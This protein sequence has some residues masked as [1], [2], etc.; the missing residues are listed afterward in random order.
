MFFVYSTLNSKIPSKYSLKLILSNVITQKY[1]YFDSLLVSIFLRTRR[2]C[3]IK[4]RHAPDS[5]R[6]NADILGTDEDSKFL[7][8]P[9]AVAGAVG[10]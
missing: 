10:G 4:S 7:R 9:G 2:L 1:R 5:L 8:T 3:L 6:E